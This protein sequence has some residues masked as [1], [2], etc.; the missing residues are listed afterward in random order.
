MPV[1]LAF[2]S[3][4]LNV[5]TVSFFHGTPRFFLIR[6][7]TSFAVIS[8]FSCDIAAEAQHRNNRQIQIRF[9]EPPELFAKTWTCERS[10]TERPWQSRLAWV[11]F[12][13]QRSRDARRTAE[14]R[15]AD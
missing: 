13:R 1:T 14:C 9:I 10:A 6:S 7:M 3:P 5:S 8:F 2:G 15:C 12:R 11:K 4:D